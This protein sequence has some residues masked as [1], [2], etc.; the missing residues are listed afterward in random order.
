MRLVRY[1]DRSFPQRWTFALLVALAIAAC[2]RAPGSVEYDTQEY[3]GF[4][5]IGTGE[6]GFVPCRGALPGVVWVELS[7][8]E[9]RRL[10]S[11]WPSVPA[12]R[13]VRRYYVRAVGTLSEPGRYGSLGIATHRLLLR[14]VREIRAPRPNDCDTA[15]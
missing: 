3:R 9:S 2:H 15:N 5:T 13:G 8:S 6:S 14:S 12:Q 1:H 7:E 10:A 11:S 4:W